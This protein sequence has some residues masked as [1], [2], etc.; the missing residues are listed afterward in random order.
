MEILQQ[1][2]KQCQ[3]GNTNKYLSDNIGINSSR[4][5]TFN[6]NAARV[7]YSVK[8]V[9]FGMF[10]KR[11]ILTAKFTTTSEQRA[12]WNDSIYSN[13]MNDLQPLLQVPV[14]SLTENL[15][16]PNNQAI[17]E[18]HRLFQHPGRGDVIVYRPE[19]ESELLPDLNLPEVSIA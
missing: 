16:Q 11:P 6:M 12:K 15:F 14:S 19:I 1:R 17:D 4:V 5:L 18:G 8:K 3:R 10:K 9:L 2:F 7:S 13:P